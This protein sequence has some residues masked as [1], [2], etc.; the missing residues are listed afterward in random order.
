M[1]VLAPNNTVLVGGNTSMSLFQSNKLLFWVESPNG[2]KTRELFKPTKNPKTSAIITHN[3]FYYCDSM[4]RRDNVMFICS[5]E[6]IDG[7]NIVLG[8]VDYCCLELVRHRS[9]NMQTI[10]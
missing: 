10:L 8:S 1:F 6:Q 3:Y 9:A 2:D 4:L 5:C 7:F